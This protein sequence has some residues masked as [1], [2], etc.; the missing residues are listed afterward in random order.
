M[1]LLQ[2]WTNNA[3]VEAAQ[4]II[5]REKERVQ[6][7]LKS[8]YENDV[9]EKRDKPPSEEEWNKALPEYM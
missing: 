9:W 5:S 8:H 4:R 3:D 6:E 2:L 1:M 7:R